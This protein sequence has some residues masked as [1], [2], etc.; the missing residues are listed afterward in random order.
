MDIRSTDSCGHHFDQQF[1]FLRFR[2]WNI[3]KNN[4]YVELDQNLSLSEAVAAY[5]KEYL[6]N[7]IKDVKNLKEASQILDVDISTVSRKLK[8]YGLSI[9]H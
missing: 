8:Q 9:K 6:K 3:T 7:V 1:I 2:F 4:A 5:E